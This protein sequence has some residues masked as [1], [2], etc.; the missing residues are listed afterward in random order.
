MSN[1]TTEVVE[2][3]PPWWADIEVSTAAVGLSLVVTAVVLLHQL[4]RPAGLF[5]LDEYDDGVYFGSALRL[6]QGHLPYR[7]FVYP[8]PPGMT[9]LMTPF[10]IVA[11]LASSRTAFAMV[12]VFTALVVLLSVWLIG[13]ILRHRGPLAVLAG[14]LS[15]GVFPIAVTANKSCMLE[16]YM[17]VMILAATAV[18]FESGRLTS[19]RRL[20]WGSALLGFAAV[21]KILTAP[22]LL[23]LMACVVLTRREDRTR[24]RTA[25]GGYL[26]GS[27]VPCL[28][29]FLATPS[30]F[31]RQ[32]I[33]RQLERGVSSGSTSLGNRFVFTGGF[34]I[35]PTLAGA[36][37]WATAIVL[38][39]GACIGISML[40]PRAVDT[41]DLFT[42]GVLMVALLSVLVPKDYFTHY[43]YYTA[44]VL[45]VCGGAAVGRITRV[46]ID[47]VRRF[48]ALMQTIAAAV[49]VAVLV[50]GAAGTLRG[51]HVLEAHPVLQTTGDPGPDI[52]AAVPKG[53]CTI[54][55]VPGLL[56]ISDRFFASPSCPSVLDPYFTWVDTDPHHPPPSDA[57]SVP[58][59]AARWQEWMTAAKYVVISDDRFRIPWS[60][61]LSVWFDSHYVP[62]I[63]G[64][65]SVYQRIA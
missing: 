41:A 23:V 30:G 46:S 26:A 51:W 47:A 29:F 19:G 64:S 2:T 60:P 14:T 55:D 50:A 33:V 36:A 16:P 10:A 17:I 12:R 15:F 13:R 56:I 3:R 28:P 20:W 61:D 22:L 54:S 48:P 58:D 40:L 59:L 4:T 6:V 49:G 45:A 65:V 11:R 27:I 7:S 18:L 57:A 31:V 52:A 24:W 53:A 38:L 43:S 21:I 8:H 5:G 1:G 44:A 9:L 25:L 42:T 37:G 34:R 63:L 39:V 32:V 35:Y 62:V